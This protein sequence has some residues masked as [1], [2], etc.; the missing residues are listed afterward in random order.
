MITSNC[1]SILC[2]RQSLKSWFTLYCCS[3]YD[4]HII[5]SLFDEISIRNSDLKYKC[6]RW[7]QLLRR[8]MCQILSVSACSGFQVTRYSGSLCVLYSYFVA[9]TGMTV[10][11][12]SEF[13]RLYI[14]W[15]CEEETVFQGRSHF[16]RLSRSVL[17]SVCALLSHIIHCHC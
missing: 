9:F 7:L 4:A 5:E 13:F 6:V 17:L 10:K 1:K 3:Q 8:F 2:S 14:S 12:W 16:P 11:G 15:L